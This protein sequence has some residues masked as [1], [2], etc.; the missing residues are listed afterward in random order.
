MPG[1]T[2]VVMVVDPSR[3]PLYDRRFKSKQ[4]NLQSHHRTL[5]FLK[6]VD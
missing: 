3:R 2:F 5:L 4:K 6:A 1:G